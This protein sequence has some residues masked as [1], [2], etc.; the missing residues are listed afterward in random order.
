MSYMKSH[1]SKNQSVSDTG[2][3]QLNNRN[4]S[5]AIKL[6]ENFSSIQKDIIGEDLGPYLKNI[7][8]SNH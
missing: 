2:N 1:G 8:Q 5:S 3:C 4:T 7:E 6:D